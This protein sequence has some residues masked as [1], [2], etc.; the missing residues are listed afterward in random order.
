VNRRRFIAAAAAGA[1]AS[2][3]GA[4]TMGVS[5]VTYD[6]VAFDGLVIFDTRPVAAAAAALFPQRGS[7][8]L[9]AWRAR[10]FEYQWLRAL[11]GRYVDFMQVTEASLD[12]GAAQLGI[13]LDTTA[14]SRLLNGFAELQIWPDVPEALTALRRSG[15]R[16][17]MLSNMTG[18]MMTN[19][20]A[21]GGVAAHFDAV[22]S[23]DAIG[24]YKP[25]PR[26]YRLGVDALRLPKER[27]LFAAFAGWDVAGA[28][29]FGYPTFWV[30]RLGAPPEELGVA[31]D[32]VGDD[33]AALVRFATESG[34]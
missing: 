11:G 32:G 5:R 18:A 34:R 25:D 24:T 28:K 21:R 20:L 23:T 4:T 17:A 14:K 9:A 22:L 6:A 8:L 15:V 30:D 27:V 10:Q 26:A 7:A 31:A 19:G 13:A 12:F 2:V 16:L 29:W 33:L 3:V 1:A